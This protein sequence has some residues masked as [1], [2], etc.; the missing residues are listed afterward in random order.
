MV[1]KHA[2]LPMLVCLGLIAAAPAAVARR[3]D[4]VMSN[5]FRCAAIGDTR[6]WLDCYYGAAQPAREALGLSPAPAGQTR[7][8]AEPPRSPVAAGDAELRDR[9]L[10]QAFACKDAADDRQWLNC[11]Y[12]AAQPARA[13]L[14]LATTV[15]PPPAPF[16]VRAAPV[17]EIPDS[18]DHIAT[19]MTSYS[20]DRY[21]IFTVTLANGQVWKQVAGDTSFAHWTKPAASYR[22]RLSHGA[23]GSYDLA[24]AGSAGLYKVRR[25]R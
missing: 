6:T 8:V 7:L 9:V 25:I 5:A 3:R 21:G 16:G 20:F 10:S 23:L 11:Y 22:I 24:V 19:A 1:F 12:A 13:R 15:P 18:A 4:D 2:I 17:S 14:G